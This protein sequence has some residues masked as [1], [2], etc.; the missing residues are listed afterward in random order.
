M[1]IKVRN[2]YTLGTKYSVSIPV[3]IH[4]IF[5]STD[6]AIMWHYSLDAISTSDDSLLFIEEKIS[7]RVGYFHYTTADDLELNGMNSIQFNKQFYF[8]INNPIFSGP[9]NTGFTTSICYP[10]LVV[11]YM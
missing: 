3:N 2:L 9:K 11:L 8:I 1:K 6:E 10:I 5:V 4:P 7:N